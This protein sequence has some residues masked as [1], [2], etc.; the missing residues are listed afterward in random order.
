MLEKVIRTMKCGLRL[1]IVPKG[2]SS[3]NCT[4]IPLDRKC[5]FSARAFAR[6]KKKYIAPF[7]ATC[8]TYVHKFLTIIYQRNPATDFDDEHLILTYPIKILS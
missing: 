2:Y 7:G 4:Y 6:A 8:L 5:T 3:Y 1:Q